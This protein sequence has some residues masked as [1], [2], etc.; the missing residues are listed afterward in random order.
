MRGLIFA[1][2][3]CLL[4]GCNETD[5]P[6]PPTPTPT[7][8]FQPAFPALHFDAPLFLTAVPGSTRLA[9]V[10]Q[11]GRIYT[12]ENRPDVA[13]TA[14]LLDIRDRV[15]AGGEM[16]LLGLA[17]DPDYADNGYL[18][19]NY[20]TDNPRRTVIARFT[21]NNSVA[22][23]GSEVVLLEYEQPYSNHNGGML[24][25]GPDGYLYIASGDGGSGGDPQNNAQSLD[26]L[27]GKILRIG[28]TPGAIIPTDN[29]FVGTPNARGEIWAY[30]LRNPWRFS[31][32]RASGDLWAGDVGQNAWEEID[33][34][35][36]GGN[37][38][39]RLF[40]G[41]HD[42]NNPGALPASNFIAPVYE[43]SHNVGQSIT[44]GH[45]YRGSAVPGL[46]GRYIYA[47]FVSGRVWALEYLNGAVLSNNQIAD[48][49][50]PSSFGEDAAGELYI[51]SFNGQ[52]YKL[53]VTGN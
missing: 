46:R 48:V 6:Q 15:L 34:I 47:D 13:A 27:L 42:Y 50:N 28:T 1:C 10:T 26:S 9:V 23:P 21:V 52:I 11:E 38:G 19:V 31:F 32:D 40:E 8:A 18:Y 35:T 3:L 25:F 39:W 51:T 4:V 53:T 17:F 5:S 33:L 2:S 12:F 36:K 16:G 20:T 14:T 41:T 7:A 22:D 44:G 43:Y 37:Y 45:V 24:A 30:G 29:P 49:E